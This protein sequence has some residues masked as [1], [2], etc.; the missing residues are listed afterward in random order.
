MDAAELLKRVR[1]VEITTRKLSDRIFSGEYSSAFKGRGMA[2]AENREYQPGDEVRTCTLGTR[3]AATSSAS[4]STLTTSPHAS[5]PITVSVGKLGPHAGGGVLP[6]VATVAAAA[7]HCTLST[8]TEVKT[9][10][11]SRWSAAVSASAACGSSDIS[12]RSER[13]TTVTALPNA[14]KA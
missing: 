1:R 11:P 14:A 3:P 13:N 8:A 6:E 4:A 7:A 5:F 9:R 12:G 2:F 10:T